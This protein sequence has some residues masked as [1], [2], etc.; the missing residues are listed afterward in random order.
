MDAV[1]LAAGVGSR[2]KELTE[3]LPKCLVKVSSKSILE[4][5]LEALFSIPEIETITIVAGHQYSEIEA[6]IDKFAYRKR[7]QLVINHDFATTN[8][9]YSLSLTSN[10]FKGKQFILCNGDVAF[11][12]ETVSRFS[13]ESRSEILYEKNSYR[14]DSMK[15]LF[16]ESGNLLKISKTLNKSEA[17]GI[18]MDIYKFS[19][20]DSFQLYE[21]IESELD[22]GH[23]DRWTEVAVDALCQS[24]D[25]HLMGLEI[26]G[27]PWFEIDNISDFE[28]ARSVF[29]DPL[30]FLGFSNYFFDLDGTLLIEDEPI[31]GSIELIS[32][33]NSL[34]KSVFVLTN[35]SGHSDDEHF[36]RLLKKGFN[37]DKRSKYTKVKP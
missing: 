30:S 15:V 24:G 6:F 35:N 7:I 19:Q 3:K 26:A 32:Y 10:N 16:D 12:S 34:G 21:Y 27:D 20:E 31:A 23:K 33:L 22:S 28:E 18:S 36:D 29:F 14:E 9:M 2:L 13:K 5:Q 1:I 8:N 37:L 17:D 25:I 11:K 4:M